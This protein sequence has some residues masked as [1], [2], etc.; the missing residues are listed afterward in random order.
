FLD[1]ERPDPLVLGTRLARR[2]EVELGDRVV[3]TAT[4][5]DGEMTRALFH[6]TGLLET[7]TRQ[8]DEVMGFTTLD[9]ARRALD[10]GA[11]VTQIGVLTTGGADPEAVAAAARDAIR[12]GGNGLE[13]LTWADAVPEMVGLVE[14]D[15][16]FGFIYMGV[17]FAVV[18]F[19]IT[20][21]FLMAVMERVREFGLLNA[22]G[23]R[24]RGIGRLMLAETLLMTGLAMAVGFGLAFAGHL[25]VARWGIAVAGYGIE[26]MEMAGIDF[27][28]LV[29]YSTI[30]PV[31]WALGSALV[32]FA[33]IASALYPAWRATRLAP[34][35]AMRFFE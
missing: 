9:A 17:I 13:V 1:D 8:L 22:L 24:H 6:L 16:A 14:L 29:I 26:E 2:L 11:A 27:S 19:S 7:G 31:K 18:L 10:M 32:A 23:L 34:A 15:D 3:L 25:A 30:N 20:N 5:P 4:R 12:A 35:E 21:T 28:D 33:T